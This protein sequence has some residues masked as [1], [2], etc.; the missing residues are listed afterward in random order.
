MSARHILIGLLL[1]S[2]LSMG[3]DR[4]FLDEPDNTIRHDF[5]EKVWKEGEIMLPTRYEE[6]DLQE[7][8]VDESSGNFH[9][10]ID[11]SSLQTS[12]DGVSR[13]ILIIRSSRGV[14][15]SSYEGMR[16]GKREYRTYAYGSPQGF[17]AIPGNVW[18]HIKK[19]GPENYRHT[20]YDDL[21]CNTNTGKANP[22]GDVLRAMRN[23]HKS[24]PTPYL[25][26]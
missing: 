15:N 17:K 23:N 13:F 1:F 4:P 25:Q 11:G 14:D 22:P 16:C 20:L 19:S 9:Y 2:P 3:E 5:T 8:Q 12:E 7:F 24:Q 21:I 18:R 10:F 26:D 6:Q